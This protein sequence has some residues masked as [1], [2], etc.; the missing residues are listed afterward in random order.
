MR[1]VLQHF[2]TIGPLAGIFLL[3]FWSGGH[4][5]ST[6]DANT[7]QL[8]ASFREHSAQLTQALQDRDRTIADL[9]GKIRVASIKVEKTEQSLAAIKQAMP[10]G[11]QIVAE[12]TRATLTDKG[13]QHET[14]RILGDLG[15]THIVLHP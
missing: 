2:V 3:V 6:Y 13:L 14:R 9:K 4:Y 7:A 5:E 1:Q 10:T 11:E 15:I 12:I 8:L